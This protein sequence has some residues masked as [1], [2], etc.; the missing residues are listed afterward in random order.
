MR[1]FL[2][3]LLTSGYQRVQHAWDVHLRATLPA[4]F[5]LIVIGLAFGILAIAASARG[6]MT[7]GQHI[8]E[9]WS[10]ITAS[11][12]SMALI[13]TV[14]LLLLA[15]VELLERM[16]RVDAEYTRKI[17]HVGAGVIYYFAPLLFPTHWPMLCLAIVFTSLF[18][19]SR[20]LGFLASLHPASR[21]SIGELI[22][23]CSIYL[24]FLLSE[25]NSLLFQIPVLVLAISDALAALVGQRF[26]RLRFQIMG[27]TRSLEGSLAFAVTAFLIVLVPLLLSTPIEG[28]QA[29]A[30]A[31][32]IAVAVTIV[33]ATSPKGMDNLSIPIATLFLLDNLLAL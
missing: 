8:G 5:M 30:F 2:T 23:P 20:H 19:L 18:V 10:E 13:G 7:F 26:G 24:V 22:Y 28:L 3:G 11:L 15:L 16:G 33:E 31:A 12:P 17:A 29:V 32:S 21:H 9:P 6:A 14:T 27:N 4:K 1:L 25:G